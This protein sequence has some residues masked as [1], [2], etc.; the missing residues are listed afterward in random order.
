MSVLLDFHYSDFLGVGSTGL[1]TGSI[2]S[3]IIIT[4]SR[5]ERNAASEAA[6]KDE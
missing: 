5:R 3:I 2:L 4:R 1:L 6:R